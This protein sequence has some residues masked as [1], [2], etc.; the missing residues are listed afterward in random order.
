MALLE[1][2][3]K[4]I[5]KRDLQGLV[6]RPAV[7]LVTSCANDRQLKALFNYLLIQHGYTP[8]FIG[9]LEK[10]AERVPQHKER[11]MTIAER[12]R[13]A[14]LRKGMREGKQEGLAEGQLNAA[15]RIAQRMLTEGIERETVQRLTGLSTEEMQSV[16]H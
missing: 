12:F 1:L 7:L 2:I 3:Q 14:I 13:N 15:R 4:H 9:F 6:E 11:L 5:R 16:I 10:V 8:R